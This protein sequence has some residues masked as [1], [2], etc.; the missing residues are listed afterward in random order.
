VGVDQALL[1]RRMLVSYASPEAFAPV[2]RPMLARLGYAILT[3]EQF[4]AVA[5]DDE[6]PDLFVA[7][8]RSL[9]DLPDDLGGRVPVVA[10]TGRYG[11]TGAD[12]RIAG[13]IQRPAGLHE[14]YRVLQELLE[15]NPRS[16]PR[17]PAHLP[18]RCQQEERQWRGAVLSLSENGCLLRSPE[19]LPL[20]SSLHVSFDLPRRG[21]LRLAGD[22]AYQ[23][24]PDLGIVFNGA[25]RRDR[26]AIADWI[27]E[28]LG[29]PPG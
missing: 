3:P 11:V 26:E 20:G 25:P 10:L 17:V 2:T 16:T 19:P 27:G 6:L 7:D 18:A 4:A 23:L 12:P 24:L 14:L 15:D 5:R 22:V 29:R 21:T 9:A 8:E 1:P 28:A 13:A